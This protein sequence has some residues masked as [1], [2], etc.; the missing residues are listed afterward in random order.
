MIVEEHKDSR[1]GTLP[2]FSIIIPVKNGEAIIKRCLDSLQRLNYPESR[3][4]IIIADGVSTDE[5]RKVAQDYNANIVN[6]PK[7]TVSPGRNLGFSEA[8]GEF[9][10]FS[11][12]DCVMDKDWLVN[13]LKYFK[14]ENVA[15]VGGPSHIPEEEDALGK[16]IGFLFDMASKFAGSVHKSYQKKVE[17]VEDI[18]GC[19]AIYRKKILEEVMPFDENLLTAEDV[20]LNYRLIKRGYR[21]LDV[22]DVCVWHYRR[23]TIKSFFRQIYRFAIGRLQIGKRNFHF[24]NLLHIAVGLFVPFI[25][26]LLVISYLVNLP[27]L[28]Y[29]LGFII[30][31]STFL[32]ATALIKRTSLG[33]AILM[34]VV[35]IICILSWSLGFLRE[36]IFPLRNPAGK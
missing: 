29:F 19:N 7:Q 23:P 24:L 1:K 15:A 9:I 13:S 30:A 3:Y 8:R 11:D 16:A 10:A 32:T 22:P 17:E 31:I 5:T 14:D 4:E 20:E 35:A 2:Y 6:N 21:I 28:M 26:F 36:L 18:P 12:V 25:I 33:C 27:M 34:P